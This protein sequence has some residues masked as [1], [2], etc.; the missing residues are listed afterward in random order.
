MAQRN[1]KSAKRETSTA[2]HFSAQD[3]AK[4]LG[5]SLATLYAYVSRGFIRSEPIGGSRRTRRYR[6]EDVRLLKQRRELR[7][8]PTKALAAALHWGDPLME[9]ALTLIANGHVYYRGQDAVALAVNRNVEEVAA[10]LW[11]GD[12]G[13][14]EQL[15]A[16][17]QPLSQ[18]YLAIRKHLLDLPTAEAFE[19]VL[20]LAAAD[21]VSACNLQP[22]VVA[23]AGARI[24][25]LLSSVAAGVNSGWNNLARTLQE[26]WAPAKPKAAQLINAALILCADHELNVSSFT[27][28]CIAS[29]GSTPYDVV[30]GGLAALRGVKHG[31]ATER[32]EAF[33]SEAG[34]PAGVAQTMVKR[35]RRGEKIP[36]FGHPLYPDG[37]PRGKTLLNL[38]KSTFP[39]SPAVAMAQAA[40]EEAFKLIGE[41]PTIDFAL[42][43]LSRALNL[44]PG[45]ALTSFALG[46]TIGWIGHAIEQYQK[47]RII[48]PRARYT[49]ELPANEHPS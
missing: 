29:A 16:D 19:V 46:R 33:L 2:P 41:R 22:A 10:L 8:N 7:R 15:F 17:Q 6:V 14:A 30:I 44:P 21:D 23:Y 45:G 31:K 28:R 49:G 4:E 25:R 5:I 40:T 39:K 13:M 35:L 37:D 47:N 34:T 48:R 12:F 1:D 36:G 42:V 9:S 3:A 38:V 11:T 20:P 26:G 18:R 43:I 27:A 24:L 32:V